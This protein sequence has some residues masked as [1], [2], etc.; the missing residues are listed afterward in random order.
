MIKPKIYFEEW[1]VDRRLEQLGLKRLE[2]IDVVR[3]TLAERQNTIEVDVLN[4]PGTLAYIHGSRHLRLLLLSKGYLVDRQKNV[5]SSVHPETGV[6]ITYQNVDQ[7]ALKLHSP[8]AISGKRSGSAS[9]IDAAQ[10]SLFS[11]DELPEVIADTDFTTLPSSMWYFCASFDE[12]NVRAELS[13]P[14]GV[15]DGNFSGFLERIF[16]I[17]GGDW[18]DPAFDD[19][20]QNDAAEF[21]PFV[22]RKQT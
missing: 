15:A 5:E 1:D 4:A 19:I 8:K 12:G 10:G 18:G 2:L 20:D 14:I 7:A 21:E 13:L 22:T 9:A 17:E 3:L 11:E 6:K 16:I